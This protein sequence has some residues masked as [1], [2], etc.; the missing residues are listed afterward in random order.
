MTS[1][2]R[3][4]AALRVFTLFGASAAVAVVM[5]AC[6]HGASPVAPT[7]GRGSIEAVQFHITVPTPPPPAHQFSAPRPHAGATV[8]PYYVSSGTTEA[9]VIVTPQGGVPYPAVDFP[10]TSASCTGNVDAPVGTDTFLVSLYGGNRISPDT[11]LSTGTTSSTIQAGV[12]NV[13]NVT[14]DPVVSSVALSL[15]PANLPPGV[16]GQS[17]VT[18]NATD[19]TGATIVGPGTYVNSSGQA[20]TIDLSTVDKLLN[21]KTGHDTTL[22]PASLNGPPASG[23][24]QVTLNYNGDPQL[25]TSKVNPT[26]TVAINGTLSGAVLEVG[27]SPSPTPIGCSITATPNPTATFFKVPP[28]NGNPQD[29]VG[30]SIADG[31]D[32]NM[33]TSDGSRRVFELTTAGKMSQF[34]IPGAGATAVVQSMASG[35]AGGTTVW[36]ADY[37]DRILG[38]VTVGSTPTVATFPVPDIENGHLAQPAGVAAGPDG[39]MWFTDRGSDYVGD[40][41]P[42][43]ANITEYAIPTDSTRIAQGDVVLPNG[44]MF[45]AESGIGKIAYV[46]ISSLQPSLTNSI[47]E[48]AV[49]GAKPG[50]LR[51]ITASPDGNVWFTEGISN[52]VG[53]V[54][55]GANPVTVDLFTVPTAGS[56]PSN[57]TAGP[58]SAIWFSEFH[59]KKLGRIAFSATAGSAAQ[60]FTFGFAAPNGI[61]TGPDCN[62]W[63][64]DQQLP[65]GRIGRISF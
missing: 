29:P 59:S 21:G 10:C 37:S 18:V 7:P 41:T 4:S 22:T 62:L 19:A 49:P 14:F 55:A 3:Q 1:L 28:N 11:L 52:K 12:T 63:V 5:A 43:L 54:N 2:S 9:A 20:L 57:L 24:T 6:G 61:V 8:R 64:T 23:P 46:Q 32:G 17:T 44:L 13:V 31:P 47:T 26:I 58:D 65:R 33:W 51:F 40:I 50:D 56:Q 45:F 60:E 15:N 38:R 35:P 16:V 39:N 34:T 27:A 36:F 42:L 25:A 48:L 53:R 30:D